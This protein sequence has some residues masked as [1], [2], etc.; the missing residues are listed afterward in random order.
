MPKKNVLWIKTKGFFKLHQVLKIIPY[1]VSFSY[2][3]H[4]FLFTVVSSCLKFLITFLFLASCALLF[5]LFSILS[6][7]LSVFC[8]SLFQQSPPSSCCN[9]TCWLLSRLLHSC[10][11][12][13]SLHFSNGLV[14]LF[15]GFH[16]CFLAL[17]PV[18]VTSKQGRW[19][20]SLN[21]EVKF[22][23]YIPSKLSRYYSSLFL[24]PVTDSIMI[25][26]SLPL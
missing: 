10:H 22:E 8:S 21:I 24:F 5:Q 20:S 23:N 25:Q 15:L 11:P 12:R 13:N 9:W 19:L 18:Q 7:L 1:F 6:L 26:I 16:V 3:S 14:S 17:F 4:D 2:L